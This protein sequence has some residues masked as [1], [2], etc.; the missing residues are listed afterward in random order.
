M[1]KDRQK[2][3]HALNHPI[4]RQIVELLDSQEFLGSTELKELLNLGPGKLYYH[5]DNLGGLIEQTEDHKYRLSTK[6]KEAY[7]LLTTGDTL[8]VK[9]KVTPQTP[10]AKL[11]TV[12]KTAFLFDWLW[13]HLNGDW[14]RQIPIAILLLL[15]GA[16]MGFV[17]GLQPILLF[18]VPQNPLL[19]FSVGQFF[20]NWLAIFA[21]IAVLCLALFQ[22]K[23]GNI[24]LLTGTVISAIPFMIFAAIW[25]LNENLQWQLELVWFGWLLRGLFLFSQAWALA[26]LTVAVSQAKILRLDKAAFVSFIVAYLSIAILLLLSMGF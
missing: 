22:R 16:W 18:Y 10:F 23:T 4:R 15:F 13:P 7:R 9:S 11:Y 2:I 3:Y 8:H 19:P 26:I 24:N 5:L 6:G 17:S 25:F 21:L 20:L 14:R 1:K 12:L